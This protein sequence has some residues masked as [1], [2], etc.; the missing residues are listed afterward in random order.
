MYPS[1]PYSTK[2]VMSALTGVLGS[3]AVL[4]NGSILALVA[5]FKSL[6]NFPNI[7]IANLA[8][9]DLLNAAINMPIYTIYTIFEASWFRGK[10]LAI[11]TAS[12]GR[13]FIVLNLASMMALVVNVYCAV[14]F[15]LKYF[16]WKTKTKAVVCAGHIWVISTVMVVLS[17]IPL[18]DIDLGD[19]HVSEYSGEIYMRAKYFVAPLMAVFIILGGVVGFLTTRSIKKR[20]QK[21]RHFYALQFS[22]FSFWCSPLFSE[23]S[24]IEME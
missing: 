19:A 7:L 15:D 11:V 3:V 20:N 13:L 9:V 22:S 21:V 6:R 24:L 8:A 10:T 17:S 23:G 14:K 5:R 2:I 18:F 4:G 12:F 1:K 16:V